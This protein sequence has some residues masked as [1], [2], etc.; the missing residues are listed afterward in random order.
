MTE[1]QK[2]THRALIGKKYK[3]GKGEEKTHWIAIGSAW[4]TEDGKGFSVKL[5]ALPLD[6]RIVIKPDEPKPAHATEDNI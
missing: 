1:N 2:P 4:P 3:N 5:D 6:G